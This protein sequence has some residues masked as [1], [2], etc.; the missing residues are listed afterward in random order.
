[1]TPSPSDMIAPRP[2]VGGRGGHLQPRARGPPLNATA[3]GGTLPP[4]AE[5]CYLP[6]VETPSPMTIMNQ[7][8][9]SYLLTLPHLNAELDA[10][11]FT[12][13]GQSADR[14]S[15]SLFRTLPVPDLPPKAATIAYMEF[16]VWDA[17]E[18]GII[19][20]EDGL[21]WERR[22]SNRS[23]LEDE[24][25]QYFNGTLSHHLAIARSPETDQLHRGLARALA[26]PTNSI[27]LRRVIR[28]HFVA[29]RTLRGEY[30]VLERARDS[31]AEL[32][33][34]PP[35]FTG[36]V[37][38]PFVDLDLERFLFEELSLYRVAGGVEQ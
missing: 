19:T 22:F 37:T 28:D 38:P 21:E 34:V 1:M 18:Q 20:V 17:V 32:S 8:T 26:T 5:P 33:H 23:A 35:D 27:R 31:I 36:V 9:A 29:F 7:N 2:P 3:G 12:A 10:L 30:L 11:T 16:V 4:P 13:A 14:A 15:R 25:V 6:S 24:R